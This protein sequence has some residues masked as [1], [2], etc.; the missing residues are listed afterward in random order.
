MKIKLSNCQGLRAFAHLK[1]ANNFKFVIDGHNY[2]MPQ[3][4]ADM[5]SPAVADMHFSDPTLSYFEISDISD[6]NLYFELFMTLAVGREIEIT[7]DNCPFI[8]AI[9]SKLMIDELIFACFDFTNSYSPITINNAVSRL[10][11]KRAIEINPIGEIKYISENFWLIDPWN[12]FQLNSSDLS[13][14]LSYSGLKVLSENWLFYFIFKIIE[15]KG[16]EYHSLLSYVIFNDLTANCIQTF[17]ENGENQPNDPYILDYLHTHLSQPQTGSFKI[18]SH[19]TCNPT[20]IRMIYKNS[21]TQQEVDGYS[22]NKDYFNRFMSFFEDSENDNDHVPRFVTESNHLDD[23]IIILQKI[24]K[25]SDPLEPK[26]EKIYPDEFKHINYYLDDS[27]SDDS[28][29]HTFFRH[30]RHR[31]IRD[32]YSIPTRKKIDITD[33]GKSE[34]IPINIKPNISSDESDNSSHELLERIM[35]EKFDQAVTFEPETTKDKENTGLWGT[36]KNYIFGEKT[37]PTNN[38]QKTP[39]DD[40][41]Y[42]H[43]VEVMNLDQPQKISVNVD[44]PSSANNQTNVENLHQ[45]DETDDQAHFEPPLETVHNTQTEPLSEPKKSDDSDDPLEAYDDVNKDQIPYCLFLFFELKSKS[46]D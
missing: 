3:N 39:N 45:N 46:H 42:Y 23:Q 17:C 43:Q 37:N 36:L 12:L 9:A 29:D 26:V 5:L 38:E 31:L 1:L 21:K 20:E 34:Q 4:L 33:L 8:E 18:P 2:Y 30:N 7:K 25:Q 28:F 35:D 6:N 14:I 10:F 11:N 16:E 13:L 15:M 19:H 27:D 24:K 32:D 41:E 22:F 40:N 44:D